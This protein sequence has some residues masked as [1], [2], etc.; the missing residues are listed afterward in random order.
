MRTDTVH[1][2]YMPTRN[3]TIDETAFHHLLEVWNRH[4]QLRSAGAPVDQLWSSRL[5][6]DE[7]RARTELVTA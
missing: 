5:E 4:Q 1:D 6:L 2:E 7:A 3:D